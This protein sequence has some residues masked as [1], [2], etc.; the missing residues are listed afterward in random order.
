MMKKTIIATSTYLILA[1]S[2]SFADKINF[3]EITSISS[4]SQ[5][6]YEIIGKDTNDDRHYIKGANNKCTQLAIE[7]A[8]NPERFQLEANTSD[9]FHFDES[10]ISYT[11]VDQFGTQAGNAVKNTLINIGKQYD[12]SY[13]LD[14]ESYN[15]TITVTEENTGEKLFTIKD[16]KSDLRREDDRENFIESLNREILINLRVQLERYENTCTLVVKSA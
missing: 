15:I 2:M 8:S 16:I 7:A 4:S 10:Y 11:A 3:S 6:Y 14:G 12:Y 13:S 9:A 1:Q 5:G